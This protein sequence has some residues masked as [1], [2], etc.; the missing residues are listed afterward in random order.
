[1]ADIPLAVD[2]AV[3][4]LAFTRLYD[5]LLDEVG[6][7]DLE[8]RL[9]ELVEHGRFTPV[10][11][12]ER[13]LDRMYRELEGRLGRR[14]D[15]PLYAAA[16]AAHRFQVRSRDQRDPAT[17][18]ATLAAISAGKGRYGTLTVFA[19]VRPDLSARER[20]LVMDIGE[21]LQM[22]DDYADRDS[23]RRAGIRT[24]ATEGRLGLA[25]VAR[26]LRHLRPRLAAHYGRGSVREFTGVC[27]LAMCVC[28]LDR[29][30]PGLGARLPVKSSHPDPGPVL[31]GEAGE[32]T[33]V[34]D[35]RGHA[36]TSA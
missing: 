9:G 7:P 12:A 6:G 13:L 33:P 24:L 30:L 1:M 26:R 17:P 31:A 3:L 25:D 11:D 18:H 16:A 35:D 22:L 34:G 32:A 19:L 10:S 8:R 20:T 23:D 15:D 29:R 14:R 4:G 28:F 27:F 2:I 5:D 21:T 36:T